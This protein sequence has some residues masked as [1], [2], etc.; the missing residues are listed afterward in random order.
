M[1]ITIASVS[2]ASQANQ[3]AR[4]LLSHCFR[5]VFSPCRNWL[6]STYLTPPRFLLR[7]L[8]LFVYLMTK[9]VYLM[10][11]LA[12]KQQENRRFAVF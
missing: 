4:G 3:L 5:I 11:T 6:A 12:Y 9:N 7:D 2:H 1:G 8:K 10:T